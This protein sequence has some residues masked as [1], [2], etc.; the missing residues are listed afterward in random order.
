MK[1][2]MINAYEV[3]LLYKHGTYKRMLKEGSHWI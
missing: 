3:G 1:K 2:V